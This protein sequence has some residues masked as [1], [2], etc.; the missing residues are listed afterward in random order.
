[1]IFIVGDI[2]YITKA[3]V[4]YLVIVLTVIPSYLRKE[5]EISEIVAFFVLRID[6]TKFESNG[7]FMILFI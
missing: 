6:E 3:K 5:N 7:I 2:Q 1:M 4:Y